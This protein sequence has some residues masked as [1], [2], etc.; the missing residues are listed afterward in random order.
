MNNP[1]QKYLKF[2]SLDGKSHQIRNLQQYG[3]PEVL[4]HLNLPLHACISFDGLPTVPDDHPQLDAILQGIVVEVLTSPGSLQDLNVTTLRGKI[5]RC[6]HISRRT[7]DRFDFRNFIAGA[8]V[9]AP[10]CI[11]STAI[12]TSQSNQLGSQALGD[13]LGQLAATVQALLVMQGA[14]N[15]RNDEAIRIIADAHAKMSDSIIQ[16]KDS[17]IQQKRDTN[18][19]FN[20]I[21][22]RHDKLESQQASSHQQFHA[23]KL[24]QD[25]LES[26][27]ANL[28]STM[29]ECIKAEIQA[30]LDEKIP[31][32]VN[33]HIDDMTTEDDNIANANANANG[34]HTHEGKEE[35]DRNAHGKDFVHARDDVQGKD[36]V[37]G[38]DDGQGKAFVEGAHRHPTA[39]YPA[40]WKQDW[41]KLSEGQRATAWT[42]YG[43][44]RFDNSAAA[45]TEAWRQ[46]EHK[47]PTPQ[48]T[49]VKKFD[50]QTS[51]LPID[52]D[53][54]F[55]DYECDS[56]DDYYDCD[57]SD[58][59]YD[60]DSSDDYD[61]EDDDNEEEKKG[62]EG[63]NANVM[64]DV[65]D[66]RTEN[67]GDDND[68]ATPS[69][70]SSFLVVLA[71][72]LFSPRN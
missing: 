16:L 22:L 67:T 35:E 55:M 52:K 13:L 5:L 62:A 71:S 34:T 2:T 37:Q 41:L 44:G 61:D 31:K 51:G 45:S 7:L 24:R 46:L 26:R 25:Q 19:Q 32:M 59:Y 30:A 9:N 53:A 15:A 20:V 21:Q 17:F 69:A 6:Y 56:S 63:P 68:T 48:A 70:T 28:Q 65:V 57:S 33:R 23:M 40:E 50:V 60:C 66:D 29:E 8:A 27:Q 10:C 47:N 18:E 39:A 4:P 58:D 72:R 3:Y 1:D 49:S 38:N 12:D 36:A 43:D 14:T 11:D 42:F 64:D 54:A